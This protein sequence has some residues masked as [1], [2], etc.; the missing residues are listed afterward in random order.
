MNN[1]ELNNIYKLIK[2]YKKEDNY[3]Q[4]LIIYKL[5]L[6]EYYSMKYKINN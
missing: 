5:L 2:K 6:N 1:S 4:L 3:E